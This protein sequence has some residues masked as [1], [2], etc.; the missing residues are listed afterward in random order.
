MTCQIRFFYGQNVVQCFSVMPSHI[1]VILV[2]KSCENAQRP[3]NNVI[4][5]VILQIAELT[6]FFNCAC[7][8]FSL[9][10]DVL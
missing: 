7:P 5:S 4:Q 8:N 3:K 6:Y 9:V 10:T 2:M 1:D